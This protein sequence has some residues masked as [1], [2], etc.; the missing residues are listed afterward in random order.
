MNENQMSGWRRLFSGRIK[1]KTKEVAL[2]AIFMALFFVTRNFKIQV[3]P[4]FAVTLSSIWVNTA[5]SLF[6]WGWTVAFPL[7]TIYGGSTIYAFLSWFVGTQV[8]FFLS[9]IVTTISP[10]RTMP[11]VCAVLIGELAGWIAY[12][13]I[14]G[15]VGLSDLRGYFISTAVGEVLYVVSAFVGSLAIWKIVRRLGIVV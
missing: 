8:V 5:A 12:G 3:T 15:I 10:N 1:N 7:A 2:A 6:S 4:V 13:A 9:K 11:Y 14:L